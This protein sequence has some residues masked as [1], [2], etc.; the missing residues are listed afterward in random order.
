MEEDLEEGV[1]HAAAKLDL[2]VC[3]CVHDVCV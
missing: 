3:V 1:E 2:C